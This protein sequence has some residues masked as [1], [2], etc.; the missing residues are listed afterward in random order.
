MIVRYLALFIL[1]G[2]SELR[3]SLKLLSLSTSLFFSLWRCLSGWKYKK[4]QRVQ[5]YYKDLPKELY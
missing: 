1:L 5:N 2:A 3:H 4:M